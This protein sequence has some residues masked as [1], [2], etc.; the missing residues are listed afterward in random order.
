MKEIDMVETRFE[1]KHCGK[2]HEN[3]ED[4]KKYTKKFDYNRKPGTAMDALYGFS[5]TRFN[6]PGANQNA[7]DAQQD[8]GVWVVDTACAVA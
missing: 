8:F 4:R 7:N 1:C 6:D 3:E 5:K 2:F